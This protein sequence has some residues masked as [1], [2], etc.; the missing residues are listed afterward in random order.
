MKPKNQVTLT[1]EELPLANGGFHLVGTVSDYA[2]VFAEVR[3]SMFENPA[4]L[5]E[6]RFLVRD[7]SGPVLVMRGAEIQHKYGGR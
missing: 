2:A 6:V 1:V 7:V 5:S 3:E 4:K